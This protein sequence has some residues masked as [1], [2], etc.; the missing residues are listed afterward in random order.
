MLTNIIAA[1]LFAILINWS[2][3]LQFAAHIEKNNKT[4]TILLSLSI[5]LAFV[6]GFILSI[7]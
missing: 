4:R 2:N 6:C 5:V 3:G 7:V 1:L